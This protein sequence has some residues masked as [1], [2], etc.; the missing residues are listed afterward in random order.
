MDQAIKVVHVDDVPVESMKSADGWA[1]SEFRLPVTG[2]DGSATTIF[3]AIFRAGSTH[4]R[5]VHTNCDE[6]VAYVEGTGVVGGGDG[7]APMGAGTVGGFPGDRSTSSRTRVRTRR[8][9]WSAST[10][11]RAASKGV[12]TST[13]GASG[14]RTSSP[15]SQASTTASS[16][17]WTRPG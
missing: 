3:Y 5:H 9:G 14:R 15:P 16:S 2:E 8:R 1:I 10:S 7:R 13:A 6:F 12:A 17:R 11:A 4:S